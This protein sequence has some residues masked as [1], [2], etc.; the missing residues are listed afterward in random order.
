[1][2]EGE[3]DTLYEFACV[4]VVNEGRRSG[5]IIRLEFALHNRLARRS[6]L[7][8]LISVTNEVAVW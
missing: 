3:E 4:F 2:P 7:E 8:G 6:Y 5:R 1:M